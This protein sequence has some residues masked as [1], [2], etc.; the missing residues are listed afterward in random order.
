ML[1]MLV[2]SALAG[3]LQMKDLTPCSGDEVTPGSTLT[4]HYEGWVQG[5]TEPFDSTRK[6]GQP[7]KL[8]HG[9]GELIEGLEI[10]L[11]GVSEGCTRRIVIPPELAQGVAT[12]WKLPPD[13]TVVFEVEILGIEKGRWPRAAPR[14]VESHVERASGVKVHD[15]AEGAGEPVK[16]GDRVTVEYTLWLTDGTLVDSSLKKKSG[17]SYRAGRGEV[18]PGWEEAVLGM[19]V[20][21]DRQFIVPWKLAYGRQGRPPRI[22]RKADLV[23]EVQLL[24]KE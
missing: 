14:P 8:R 13:S 12:R 15:F 9:T 11:Q 24:S 22:P 3:A 5:E 17:F 19:K 2:G 4:M 1:A 16:P 20:G 6:R 7:V 18:I 10:G 23:F 21:G